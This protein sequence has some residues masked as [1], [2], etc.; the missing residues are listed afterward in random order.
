TPGPV[1]EAVL[2]DALPRPATIVLR[3]A[4][5]ARVLGVAIADAEVERILRALGLG[6]EADAEGWTV[7]APTRRFDL[8]IEEDL[9][10][11]VARIHGY[12]AVPT[13]LPGGATRLPMATETQVPEQDLR[14]AMAGRGYLEA[15]NYAFVDAA[16]LARWQADEPLVPLANP[17]SAELGVMRPRLLPGLVDALGRN[18][19]RQQGRVRLFELGKVFAAAGNG[20]APR[21]TPRIAAV[22]TGEAAAEQWGVPARRVDFHDLK[23][24][25]EALAAL[26]GARLAFRA[27]A[28]PWGHPGRSAEV[29]RDGAVVGAIAEL[30]PRLQQALGLDHPAVA[31]GLELAAVSRRAIPR[32]RRLSRFPSVRRDLACMV[33]DGVSWAELEA[34]ARAAAG[35]TLRS[36]R[37]FDV[38]AGKG[39]ET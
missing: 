24:E 11:E 9:I 4:R 29:L 12:D 36:L 32:A 10:E 37:L 20:D 14:R 8:A 1:A 5:L 27:A 13:T 3:R 7:T 15:I 2:A 16:L 30:H 25:L 39:V 31:F 21:E 18:A 17:L 28:L 33:A 38:Y 35:P 26:S 34:T 23:G 6:V 19:A 22:A